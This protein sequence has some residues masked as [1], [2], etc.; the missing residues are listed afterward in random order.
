LT[1]ATRGSSPERARRREQQHDQAEPK[2][3][4]SAHPG[5]CPKPA[6]TRR[7]GPRLSAAAL[8]AGMVLGVTS[9]QQDQRSRECEHDPSGEDC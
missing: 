1:G 8:F 4:E 7:V 2:I 3:G 6:I 5:G 9:P